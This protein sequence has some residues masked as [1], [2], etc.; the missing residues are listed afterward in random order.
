[1]EPG[2]NMEHNYLTAITMRMLYAVPAFVCLEQLE[3]G[4]Y[5]INLHALVLHFSTARDKTG[6]RLMVNTRPYL[7][8]YPLSSTVIFPLRKR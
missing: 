4:E 8:S 7:L 5:I 6:A 2:W 3:R 1:M